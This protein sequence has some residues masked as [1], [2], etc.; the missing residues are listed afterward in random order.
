MNSGL[1]VLFP[2]CA[3]RRG[4]SVVF[5]YRSAFDVNN[6]TLLAMVLPLCSGQKWYILFSRKALETREG[7]QKQQTTTTIAIA[8]IFIYDDVLLVHAMY[9]VVSFVLYYCMFVWLCCVHLIRAYY[10]SSLSSFT[11]QVP[12][13]QSQ[14]YYCWLRTVSEMNANSYYWTVWVGKLDLSVTG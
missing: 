10:R 13:W 2:C 4:P 14:F 1:Q 3:P 12:Q 7:H 5:I 6:G 11:F 9:T 8:G